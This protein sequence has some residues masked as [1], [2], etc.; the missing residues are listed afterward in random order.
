[1]VGGAQSLN[2]DDDVLNPIVDDDFDILNAIVDDDFGVLNAI[3]DGVEC[4][5]AFDDEWSWR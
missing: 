1:M 3:I 4:T 5:D 2:A